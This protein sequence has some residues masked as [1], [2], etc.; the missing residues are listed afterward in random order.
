MLIFRLI[1][2]KIVYTAHNVFPHERTKLDFLRSKI[3]FKTSHK[4]IVHSNFI[5][6]KILQNFPFCLNKISI[7]PHGNFDNYLSKRSM[8]KTTARNVLN[9]PKVGIVL[10]FFGYIREYKGLDLLIDAF[11]LA[12][13]QNNSLYLVIAGQPFSDDLMLKY[14]QRIA[15]IL[16]HQNIF[17][18]ILILSLVKILPH[19]FYHRI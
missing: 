13:K 19:I 18:T 11:E 12:L 2:I 3:I 16:F 4:L 14:E 9:L 17:T 8:T 7:I 6:N 5:K 15:N 10:L 1:G